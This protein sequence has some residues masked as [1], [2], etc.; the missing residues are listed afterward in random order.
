M[1]ERVFLKPPVPAAQETEPREE[2][3]AFIKLLAMRLDVRG[4]L[5]AAPRSRRASDLPERPEVREAREERLGATE[6]AGTERARERERAR[7]TE[8]MCQN[9]KNPI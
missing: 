2:R 7:E 5:G 6:R 9:F 4:S 1:G 8:D 3:E